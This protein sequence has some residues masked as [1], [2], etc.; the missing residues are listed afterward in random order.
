MRNSTQKISC[1]NLIFEKSVL[2]VSGY[3]RHLSSHD[4][5]HLEHCKNKNHY[6]THVLLTP[7]CP[8]I[9]ISRSVR[10]VDMCASY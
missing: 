8:V 2:T 1:E 10:M 4:G 3:S 7:A 6:L 9:C 5:R